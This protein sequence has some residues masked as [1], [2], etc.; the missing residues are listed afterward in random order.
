[1]C[2]QELRTIGLEGLRKKDRREGMPTNSGY[3]EKSQTQSNFSIGRQ[4]TTWLEWTV[5]RSTEDKNG[6]WAQ[7]RKSLECQA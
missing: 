1:M 3:S 6:D 7:T 5:F 4:L 2:Y